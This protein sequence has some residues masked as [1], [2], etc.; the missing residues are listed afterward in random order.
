MTATTPTTLTVP[1]TALPPATLLPAPP[2]IP[3]TPL[4]EPGPD[5]PSPVPDP[6]RTSRLPLR[7]SLAAQGSRPARIDGAWWPYSRDLTAELPALTG[8]LDAYWDRITRVTV[9]PA[10]WPVIPRKVQVAGHVVKVG[11]FAQEQ[12]PHQLMLLS[13]RTGRWDLLV[14]PPE[15]PEDTAAWLMAAAADPRR[16]VTG[17]A[18]MDEAAARHPDDRGAEAGETVWESEGGRALLPLARAAGAAA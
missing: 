4:P 15:T 3:L 18:L 17:S 7:V 2:G 1:T 8:V 9:N 5:V 10:H 13:Y 11:W 12:D 14:I 6:T 16:T